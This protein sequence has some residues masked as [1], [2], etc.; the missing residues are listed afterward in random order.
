MSNP[1][2]PPTTQEEHPGT[3]SSKD[4]TLRRI[5]AIALA[6]QLAKILWH[7]FTNLQG[8]PL[9]LALLSA[10]AGIAFIGIL[11][12]GFLRKGKKFHLGIALLLALSIAS[13]VYTL[14]YAGPDP[15]SGQANP[16]LSFAIQIIPIAIAF[17]CATALY[18]R[19]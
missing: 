15:Q 12:Y 4:T 7:D 5:G 8:Y 13:Q 6:C 9:S 3:P 10:S 2:T 1:Y 17:L 18:R 16:S 19:A 11:I 14:W